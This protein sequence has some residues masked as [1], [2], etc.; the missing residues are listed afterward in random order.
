M[1]ESSGEF[2]VVVVGAGAA[3][4]AAAKHLVSA[5]LAVKVIEAR[6]RLGG[7]AHTVPSGLGFG[8]DLGCEW[9]HSADINPWTRIARDLGFTVD[10]TLPDWGRRVAWFEGDAAQREWQEAMEAFYDRL[11]RAAQDGEDRPASSVLE[12]G[13]KWNALLGAISNWANG[14][15]LD[16]VSVWD[17]GGYDSTYLN[18]RVIEG[19]GTVIA[20]YGE[21]LPIELG[22]TVERIDHGG[23]NI[24][25][26]TNRGELTAC[27]VIVTLPTTV[28]AEERVKFSPPLA[29]KVA[30]AAGL[31]L[32]IVNKLFLR[33][34]EA[35][36]RELARES[37]RHLVGALDRVETGSY[38]IKPHGW[39]VVA[40]FFGGELSAELERDGADAMAE[41]ARNELA[42]L[43]GAAIKPHLSP[44]AA[45]AW[46]RN[47]FSRGS[48]S[49]ALPG[50]ASDRKVLAAPVDGRLFFAGEACSIPHFGTAH[51]AYLSGEAAAID[52]VAALKAARPEDSPNRTAA[53]WRGAPPIPA[54]T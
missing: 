18:W 42:G 22:T 54:G 29:D 36:A 19:Y 28:L 2:D 38:Q 47:A 24:R 46:G 26:A 21:G 44:I 35:G 17:Y 10:E 23:H 5:R 40:G 11:D 13:G 33:L 41:F 37:D 4:I 32:G 6:E 27:A 31:P 30:A 8:I 49:M 20:R 14:A 12:P 15:E 34:D 16:K 39:P 43:F 50:H 51:G 1:T 48:Y 53:A 3:G 25:I 7:R 45:S 9:L 52:A